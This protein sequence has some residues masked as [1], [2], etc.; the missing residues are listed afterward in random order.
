[1]S[2]KTK[3]IFEAKFANKFVTSGDVFIMAVM[4]QMVSQFKMFKPVQFLFFF[5]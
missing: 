2:Y 4:L 5:V 3:Q 1:M